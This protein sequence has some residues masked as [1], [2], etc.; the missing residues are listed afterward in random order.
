MAL[1]SLAAQRDLAS[2]IAYQG[3]VQLFPVRFRGSASVEYFGGGYESRPGEFPILEQVADS[4]TGQHPAFLLVIGGSPMDLPS[5]TPL[6][7]LMRDH[8]SPIAS[9]QGDL[10]PIQLFRLEKPEAQPL[11]D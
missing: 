11:G 9:I 7:I 2:R 3:E 10:G 8:A 5:D 6:A 1:R 4:W